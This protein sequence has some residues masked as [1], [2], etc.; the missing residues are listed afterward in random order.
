MYNRQSVQINAVGGEALIDSV[1]LLRLQ[2][3]VVSFL[4]EE[5]TGAKNVTRK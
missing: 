3:F 5:A 1:S 4:P 2:N